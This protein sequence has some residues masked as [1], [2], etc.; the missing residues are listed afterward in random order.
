MNSV[1]PH[2]LIYFGEQYANNMQKRPFLRRPTSRNPGFQPQYTQ[3]DGNY[4]DEYRRNRFNSRSPSQQSRQESR[5]FKCGRHGHWRAACP[6][7]DSRSI[8]SALRASIREIGE[9]P[10]QAAAKRLFELV[11]KEDGFTE[12]KYFHNDNDSEFETLAAA[13]ETLD[14][15]EIPEQTDLNNADGDN[16]NADFQRAGGQ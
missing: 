1:T 12:A 5:C 6:F 11:N 7:D 16:Q 3:E 9:P 2:A 15:V 4:R 10:N 13:Y 14:A 8:I